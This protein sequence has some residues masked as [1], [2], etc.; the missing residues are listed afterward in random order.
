MAITTDNLL[1]D[2]SV[3]TKQSSESIRRLEAQFKDLADVMKSSARSADMATKGFSKFGASVVSINQGLDLVS[4]GFQ[5]AQRIFDSTVVAFKEAEDG[6]R[7]LGIALQQA[8]DKDVAGALEHF[9]NFADLMQETTTAEGDHVIQL[10]ALAKATGVSNTAAEKLAKTAV[11]LSSA[12]GEDLDS[13]FK[14]LL[15]TM[16]GSAGAVAAFAPELKNLTE[17][18]LKSGKAV[19]YLAGKFKGFGEAALQTFG[20]QMAQAKNYL[21]DIMEEIGHILV[22]GFNL[23]GASKSFSESLQEILGT[24]KEYGGAVAGVI[25]DLTQS[26]KNFADIAVGALSKVV[27]GLAEFGKFMVKSSAVLNLFFEDKAKDWVGKLDDLSAAAGRFAKQKFGNVNFQLTEGDQAAR[28]FAKGIELLGKAQDNAGKKPPIMP[29]SEDARKAVEDLR[30]KLLDLQKA[31]AAAGA[32]AEDKLRLD[33]AETIQQLGD[34][35]K[36]LK[37]VGQLTKHQGE[38]DLARQAAIGKLVRELGD[39]QDKN[40][41]EDL[42]NLRDIQEQTRSLD[43]ILKASSTTQQQQIDMEYQAQK[44]L[45]EAKK[46]ELA[47]DEASYD[48]HVEELLALDDEE[49]KLAAIAEKKKKAAASELFQKTE[50]AGK[51][52]ASKIEGIYRQGV[53]SLIGGAA[54][55]VG[56]VISAI[57]SL[58]SLIPDLLDKVAAIPKNL[59]GQMQRLFTALSSF[60]VNLIPDILKNVPQII[61]TILEGVFGGIPRA[62]AM[63]M[64]SVPQLLISFFAAFPDIIQRL[65]SDLL[66]HLPEIVT[67]LTDLLIRG[68]PKFVEVFITKFIPA[69]FKGIV[70]GFK[71]GVKRIG[72]SLTELFTG[73]K[74]K[75]KVDLDPSSLKSVSKSLT[76]EASKVFAVMD[77]T[78]G[79]KD[80]T[81]EILAQI[82]GAAKEAGESIWQWFVKKFEETLDWFS[83]RGKEVWDGLVAAFAAVGEWFGKRGKEIWTG[84]IGAIDDIVKWFMARGRDIW[85][86][87]IKALKDVG[88]A[89]FGEKGGEI[90]AGVIEALGKAG[91]WFLDLGE[92]I[93]NGL[94][95]VLGKGGTWFID[96]GTK[97]WAGLLTAIGEAGDWFLDL[98]KKIWSGFVEFIKDPVE[99][100]KQL[101]M[102]IWNGLIGDDK[103]G[104]PSYFHNLGGKIWSGFTTAEKDLAKWF[105]ARGGEIW[106]GLKTAA[107]TIVKPFTDLGGKIFEGLKTAVGDVAKPFTDWGGK[108]WSGFKTVI[109]DAAK[110]FTE[111]GGKIWEGLKA[112]VGTLAKSFTDWGGKIWAGLKA[113]VEDVGSLFSD[114]GG[115]IWTGLKDGL[116]G[117]GDAVKDSV[118]TLGQTFVDLG[119]KIWEGLSA[120]FGSIGKL[121]KDSL[122][123]I[124]PKT[125]QKAL[126]LAEGGIIGGVAGVP[127]DSSLN[128]K[129]LALLSPGEAVIPRSAMASPEILATV[130]SILSGKK[131]YHSG[132]LIPGYAMGGDIGHSS[133][134]GISSVGNVGLPFMQAMGRG[135]APSGGGNITIQKI[136]INTEQPIDE[137]FFRNK[138]LP[139]VKEELRRA[140]LDGQTTTYAS[141]VR[142][143]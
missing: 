33:F 7:K 5:V 81:N 20:G 13:S 73:K 8:G 14:A 136:E 94:I 23:D 107:E 99:W 137:A 63:L 70:N 95:E 24:L 69:L 86:G 35:E 113:G 109:G 60:I 121:V 87:L 123:A 45:I 55:A 97:I 54:S 52:A 132:G 80:R 67:S 15:N 133:D 118:S 105:K 39:L 90:W 42:K 124:L 18:E 10:L 25:G 84:L 76:G 17:E 112:A 59:L 62:I 27:Q 71:E 48:R 130:R 135:G 88:K 50:A 65:I 3:N 11:D 66:A 37:K 82:N 77:F 92:K 115:T 49:A 38:L 120:G 125:V 19:D 28:R 30:K 96:L 122:V 138:L 41:R 93:W 139:R 12:T 127:G 36:Q 64:D 114:L 68:L 29:I 141:G 72:A 2:V 91:T 131:G 79:V 9:Q 103:E 117:F 143:R 134:F 6:G 78:E 116:S 53:L 40:R 43:A 98:G 111:W 4:R 128:D 34:V 110:P 83:K 142:T 140:S 129:V 126:G 26:F 100:F 16:K 44:R 57:D 58:L 32:T 101:G 119:G 21:G 22:A 31:E 74:A 104:I 102:N 51:N 108:I 89:V 47:V 85:D 56:L 106:D 1:I 75:L 61:K 46:A